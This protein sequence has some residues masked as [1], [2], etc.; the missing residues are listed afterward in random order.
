MSR[1]SSF[2]FIVTVAFASSCYSPQLGPGAGYY[3]HENDKPACPDGQTCM[4]G[5]CYSKGM[6]P[7]PGGDMAMMSGQ[8][9]STHQ[10]FSTG[11]HDFAMQSQPDFSMP[12][13]D[14][15]SGGNCMCSTKCLTLCVGMNCC[16]EDV[17][18]MLCTADPNCTPN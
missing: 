2:V 17:L 5:R 7:G 18:L 6:M 3:C 9:G 8:D 12:S 14:Q 4:G 16:A 15:G 13:F 11:N 10:D 1:L